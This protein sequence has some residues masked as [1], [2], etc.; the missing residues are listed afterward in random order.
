MIITID[1]SKQH[2]L[3]FEQTLAVLVYCEEQLREATK[4]DSLKNGLCYVEAANKVEEASEIIQ[5]VKNDNKH[6]KAAA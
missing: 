6:Q 2:T 1:T 5:A 4:Y 3:S